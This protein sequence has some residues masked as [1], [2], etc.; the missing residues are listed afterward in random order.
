MDNDNDA[1]AERVNFSARNPQRD[2]HREVEL[3][4]RERMSADAKLGYK[5]AA[6]AVFI[7]DPDLHR[8]YLGATP[9]LRPQR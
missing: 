3:R 2:A 9:P 8:L 7:A 5:E 1:L 6:H 4:V